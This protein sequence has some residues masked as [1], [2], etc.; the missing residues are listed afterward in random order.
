M[1]TEK[2][3]HQL[4]AYIKSDEYIASYFKIPVNRVVRLRTTMPRNTVQSRAIIKGPN[5]AVGTVRIADETG[6]KKGSAKLAMAIN[7][8]HVRQGR[9]HFLPALEA[10][11]KRLR[12]FGVG[13]ERML[14]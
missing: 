3:I 4:C 10:S 9:N 1:P 6:A 8:Y 14:L 12:E 11:E 13:V 7:L 5:D 2:E